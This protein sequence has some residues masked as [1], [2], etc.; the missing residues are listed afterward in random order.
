MRHTPLATIAILL[1]PSIAAAAQCG[2]RGAQLKEPAICSRSFPFHGACGTP[3][4]NFPGWDNVAVAVGAWEKV[5]IRIVSVSTDAIVTTKRSASWAIIFAGNS[6]NA[7]EMT[8]LQSA[9]GV[10][11]GWWGSVITSVHS[12]KTFPPGLGMQ[13]P[14][15]QPMYDAHLDVH[16][17]CRP[18]GAPYFGDLTIWYTLDPP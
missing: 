1:M 9:V 3:N 7:D 5:P 15:G 17:E 6:F 2:D 18:I 8:P 11:S 4:Y 14:A 10:T 16:L 13:F 12:E